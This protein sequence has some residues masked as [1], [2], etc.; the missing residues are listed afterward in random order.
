MVT[1]DVKSIAVLQNKINKLPVG[2]KTGIVSVG[3]ASAYAGVWEWGSSRISKPG[4]KTTWG[5]NPNGDRVILTITAPSGYIRVHAQEF[6]TIIKEEFAKANFKS[7]GIDGLAKEIQKV[8]DRAILRCL[9][10]IKEG[11]PEDT[12]ALKESLQVVKDGDP[13]LSKATILPL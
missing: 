8:Y 9:E 4:P 12:G 2:I 7:A 3:P 6:K 11:A 5:V 13:I 10:I 1:V